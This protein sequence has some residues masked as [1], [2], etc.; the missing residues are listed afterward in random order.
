MHKSRNLFAAAFNV[1]KKNVVTQ[2]KDGGMQ[3][4]LKRQV[5]NF[6]VSFFILHTNMSKNKFSVKSYTSL[7]GRIKLIEYLR[8]RDCCECFVYKYTHELNVQ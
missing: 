8:I 6:L 3:E 1:K 2:I 4:C 5:S 7:F